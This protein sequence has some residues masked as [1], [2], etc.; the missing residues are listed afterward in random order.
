MTS[1]FNAAPQERLER[2]L[3]PAGEHLFEEGD[4][5]DC[6]YLIHSG[7]IAISQKGV[8][9]AILGPNTMFGE[10]ALLDG[11]PRMAT[12]TAVEQA[13]L[14]VVAKAVFDKKMEK[15]DPFLSRLIRIMLKNLRNITRQTVA[16]KS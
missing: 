6:A 2:R 11:A 1:F 4:P 13:V 10:M 12:A 9:L 8:Q 7:K 14:I 3:L 16:A 15:A 5:G